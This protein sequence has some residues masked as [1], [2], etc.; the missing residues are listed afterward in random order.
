MKIQVETNKRICKRCNKIK[1]RIQAG[2]FPNNKDKK[3]V[4]DTGKQWSGSMCPACVVELAR[5][6]KQKKKEVRE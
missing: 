2:K 6:R 5:L 1:D 3:W 4:D